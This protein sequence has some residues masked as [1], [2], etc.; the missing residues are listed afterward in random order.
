MS[1]RPGLADTPVAVP[2]EVTETPPKDRPTRRRRRRRILLISLLV[3]LLLAGAGLVAGGLYLHSVD[4]SVKRVDA[5]SDVPLQNR[6]AKVA[7]DAENMLILGSDSRDPN[8][9]NGTRSDT[10]I[11]AH[12]PKGRGSAQLI[13]IPRDTWVHIPAA[14]DGRHG[15]ADAKINAALAW[16]GIPLVVQTIESFTGVRIDH[17]A[18][19]DFAGFKEIIDALGGVDIYVDH[20]FTSHYS[21]NPNGIR[22][23][24][25]GWQHMD[26]AA[27]LDYSRERHA[28]ADGDFDR[29]KHQ[30]QMIKAVLDKAAN[31][32]LLSNPAALNAFITA[33]AH[34]V[35][36]DQTMNL[37]DTAMEL[38]GL[39]SGSLTFFTSPSR[40]TGMVGTES[41][42]FADTAKA[43]AL[44]DA[45]RRDDVP[46]I[47]AAAG[48]Q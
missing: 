10:I 44:F 9:L 40:G 2:D 8:N 1:S 3:V 45:V 4:S 15:N 27:A 26:G 24:G 38:R 41:V 39:R 29:I 31:G 17:V 5:F 14:K 21:L 19:I 22:Q 28:F 30:Q 42:V 47:T 25:Q 18:I 33:S 32:G 35:S 20:A 11:L 6:P 16:G 36:V 48:K 43:K 12:L 23:F 13:S 46:A 34:A 7:A 37:I